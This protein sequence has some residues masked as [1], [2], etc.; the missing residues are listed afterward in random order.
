MSLELG[1]EGVSAHFDDFTFEIED[2]IYEEKKSTKLTIVAR[3]VTGRFV[4]PDALLKV[5]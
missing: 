5:F 1:M 4:N 3:V 2:L